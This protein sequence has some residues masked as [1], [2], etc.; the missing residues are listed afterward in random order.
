MYGR[1]VALAGPHPNLSVAVQ[2]TARA[3]YEGEILKKDGKLVT[4]EKEAAALLATHMRDTNVMMPLLLECAKRQDADPAFRAL[5]DSGKL[6]AA[7]RRTDKACS[8][9]ST[10]LSAAN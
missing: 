9:S 7:A 2:T 8:A 10:C 3:L 1:A 6:M 5:N 4:G